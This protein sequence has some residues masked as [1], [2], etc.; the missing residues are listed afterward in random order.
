[1]LAAPRDDVRQG[2]SRVLYA[3]E[4]LALASRRAP[5]R[6]ARVIPTSRGASHA[7]ATVELASRS[8]RD[9]SRRLRDPSEAVWGEAGRLGEASRGLHHGA[10][11]PAGW[12]SP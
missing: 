7:S 11:G 3:S 5:H 10:L 8:V 2:N 1:M 4:G 6:M 12:L 9:T